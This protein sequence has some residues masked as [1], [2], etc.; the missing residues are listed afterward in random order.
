MIHPE[1]IGFIEREVRLYWLLKNVPDRI[2][3]NWMSIAPN[4]RD[5]PPGTE[6]S[7]TSEDEET[8]FVE[9]SVSRDA[10]PPRTYLLQFVGTLKSADYR[11]VPSAEFTGL[12]YGPDQS[13]SRE[14]FIYN[15]GEFKANGADSIL[16]HSAARFQ[17]DQGEWPVV[18]LFPEA[19]PKLNLEWVDP[20]G[21][22]SPEIPI[23]LFGG[24]A[25]SSLDYPRHL[26]P[27][28]N[29]FNST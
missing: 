17:L 5:F 21:L 25:V 14:V 28:H 27:P 6:G 24:A 10:P 19:R 29:A 7:H 4:R 8:C 11:S 15:S 1:G 23:V 3:L 2:D 20:I 16:H 9:V 18:A 26:K 12:M 22:E 13:Y